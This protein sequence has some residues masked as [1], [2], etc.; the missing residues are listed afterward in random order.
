MYN[1]RP[2]GVYGAKTRADE[3]RE[4]RNN[5]GN[6]N[7]ITPDLFKNNKAFSQIASDIIKQNPQIKVERLQEYYNQIIDDDAELLGVDDDIRQIYVQL[8]N[9]KVPQKGLARLQEIGGKL[10][11]IRGNDKQQSKLV[12]MDYFSV[13]IEKMPTFKFNGQSMIADP[14]I[15]LKKIRDNFLTLS[16]GEVNFESHC[17]Y[18]HMNG[19]WQFIPYPRTPKEEMKRWENRTGNTIFKIEAKS[20]IPIYIGNMSMPK[21]LDPADHGAVLESE[22]LLDSWIFTTIYTP[23]TDTQPFSG[24]RQFGIGKDKD[25]YYRFFARAID[26]VWPSSFILENNGKECSVKDYLTI[27]DATWTNLIKNVSEYIDNNN[28]K[29]TIM[30]SEIN[31]IDFNIFFSKFRSDYPVNFVGNIDQH[32]KI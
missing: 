1:Y 31:R 32:K 30:P 14:G 28:G 8:L 18:L 21:I 4:D 3:E 15:L 2:I 22:T 20:A 9:F 12:N 6:E 10:Q 11:N 17:R 24:H 26:R 25:G 5:S 16:K 7:K 13:R 19:R 23:K 29:T 27:A